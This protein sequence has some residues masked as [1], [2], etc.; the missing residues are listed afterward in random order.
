MLDSCCLVNYVASRRPIISVRINLGAMCHSMK[1]ICIVSSG[2]Q[3]S[4]LFRS[5]PP[6]RSVD[7]LLYWFSSGSFPGELC[8]AEATQKHIQHLQ[9]YIFCTCTRMCAWEKNEKSTNC[10]RRPVNLVV[11]LSFEYFPGFLESLVCGGRIALQCVCFFSQKCSTTVS[12]SPLGAQKLFCYPLDRDS[13][14]CRL[15]MAVSALT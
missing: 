10:C 15:H 11:C 8:G 12:L 7:V 1:N 14:L 9:A 6:T 3:T 2:G 5:R 13:P 4:L